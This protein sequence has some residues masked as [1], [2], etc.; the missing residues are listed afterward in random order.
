MATL[1]EFRVQLQLRVSYYLVVDPRAASH[2]L[3][4]IGLALDLL[5]LSDDI[6]WAREYKSCVWPSRYGEPHSAGSSSVSEQCYKC[7]PTL[8]G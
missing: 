4:L 1:G 5:I 8:I 6:Y 3:G 7:V 2:G